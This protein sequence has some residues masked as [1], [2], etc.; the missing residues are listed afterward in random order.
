MWFNG[1]RRMSTVVCMHVTQQTHLVKHEAVSTASHGRYHHLVNADLYVNAVH[2]CPGLQLA[3]L[4][5][6]T[7]IY[8]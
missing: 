6:D 8:S 7:F 4:I 2:L 3:Y 5:K 1:K